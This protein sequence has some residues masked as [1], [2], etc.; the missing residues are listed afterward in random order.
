MARKPVQPSTTTN[1]NFVSR[2]KL[3]PEIGVPFVPQ[4]GVLRDPVAFST[5]T[6]PEYVEREERNA[7]I[8]RTT[9][10]K[11][12]EKHIITGVERTYFRSKTER[13]DE[14]NQIV[15]IFTSSSDTPPPWYVTAI[16][17]AYDD[18]ET[19]LGVSDLQSVI[20]KII[21]MTSENI[22]LPSLNF[23]NPQ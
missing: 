20:K 1:P 2:D 3:V 23:H 9:V 5:T 15:E 4:A 12:F 14:R 10:E 8:Y 11:V 19:M 21:S 13:Y 6:N 7:K 16:E 18:T 17:V 22:D